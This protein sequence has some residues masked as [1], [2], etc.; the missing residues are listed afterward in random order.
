MAS[1][2]LLPVLVLWHLDT[3]YYRL[4]RAYRGLYDAIR[5][6]AEVEPFSMDCRA[7]LEPVSGWLL[8]GLFSRAMLVHPALLIVIIIMI[9]GDSGD[10]GIQSVQPAA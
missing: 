5:A 3:Y 6:G 2:C 9:F 4:E 10:V 7:Y 1:I 8:K